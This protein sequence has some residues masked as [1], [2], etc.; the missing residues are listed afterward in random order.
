[1]PLDVCLVY[2]N[3]RIVWVMKTDGINFVIISNRYLDVMREG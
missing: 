2:F 1:M 3:V